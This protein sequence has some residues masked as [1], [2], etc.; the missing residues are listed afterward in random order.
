MKLNSGL[1][2][3]R[4]IVDP[5]QRPTL[6]LN[7]QLN[8]GGVCHTRSSDHITCNVAVNRAR[9]FSS[10]AK[11]EQNLTVQDGCLATFVK[12]KGKCGHK[13]FVK[14]LPYVAVRKSGSIDLRL[15]RETTKNITFDMYP[16]DSISL[17]IELDEHGWLLKG[18]VISTTDT[19]Q[20]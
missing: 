19:V 2:V 13:A 3:I 15:F 7:P 1:A 12:I 18:P 5:I 17:N 9:I 14:Y 4:T 11:K 10:N 8:R 16:K 20:G 6:K